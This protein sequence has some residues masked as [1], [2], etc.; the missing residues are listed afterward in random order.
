MT[1]SSDVITVGASSQTDE[2]KSAA[3]ADGQFSWGSSYLGPG[4]D[5]CAPGPWSYTTDRVGPLGYNGGASGVDADYH[6]NFGGTSASTPKVAGIVALM[7]SA[8]S[9][10]TP[11][12]VKRILQDTADDIEAP[13]YDDTTGAGRVNALAAVRMAKTFRQNVRMVPDNK[14]KRMPEDPVSHG[15]TDDT[16]GDTAE[17]TG[18]QKVLDW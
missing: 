16:A 1:A 3:S 12:Q 10:L 7:L 6:H 8:N 5:I 4:P 9:D 18:F 11:A 15:G 17:D 13:G 2:H 14:E